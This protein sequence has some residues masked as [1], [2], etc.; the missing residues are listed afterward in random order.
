MTRKEELRMFALYH[1]MIHKSCD[2]KRTSADIQAAKKALSKM[3][4][5]FSYREICD[6]FERT[7]PGIVKY[8]VETEPNVGEDGVGHLGRDTELDKM[9]ID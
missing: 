7:C 4:R 3:T 2:E 6:S 1:D 9:P 5:K 8:I